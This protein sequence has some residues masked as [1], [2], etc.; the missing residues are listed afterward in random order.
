MEIEG[1]IS[2]CPVAAV[3]FFVRA[4]GPVAAELCFQQWCDGLA[5]LEFFWR[6]RL[7][8]VHLL[9]PSLNSRV[10][11]PANRDESEERLRAIFTGH[12]NGLLEGDLAG[13]KIGIRIGE[14]SAEL[15]KVVKSLSRPQHLKLNLKLQE[16]RKSLEEELGL[17]KG[18][19]EEFRA[20]MGCLLDHLGGK[21][22]L[23]LQEEGAVEIFGLG[24]ELD[25]ARIHHIILREC[26]RLNSS[27]PIYSCRREILRVLSSNQV[28]LRLI[29]LCR[30]YCNLFPE[31]FFFLD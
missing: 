23:G 31:S 28:L 7:E 16:D 4:E 21:K 5:A 11:V 22:H 10:S 1:L 20:A 29:W 3:D 18:M 15:E 27:L 9:T 30:L 26:K 2:N 12:I 8:G 25:W 24:G 19:R 14:L 6:R 17:L 13:K